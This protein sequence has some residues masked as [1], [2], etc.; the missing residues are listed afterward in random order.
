MVGTFTQ[1]GTEIS[2]VQHLLLGVDRGTSFQV[3]YDITS[4]GGSTVAAD[5]ER[6]L[7]QMFNAQRTRITAAN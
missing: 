3:S 7:V 5:V 1:S 6:N 4:T 2:L